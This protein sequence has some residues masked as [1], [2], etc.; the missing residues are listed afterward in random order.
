[1]GKR[2]LFG[3][4]LAAPSPG[5]RTVVSLEAEARPAWCARRRIPACEMG[6]RSRGRRTGTLA[7]QGPPAASGPVEF[8]RTA[9]AD[10]LQR[11]VRQPHD[12]SGRQAG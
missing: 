8:C 4:L 7:L 3:E 10:R 11:Q 2:A 6:G 5:R 9:E 12:Q 1:M